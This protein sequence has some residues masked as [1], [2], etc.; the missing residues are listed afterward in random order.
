MSSRFDVLKCLSPSL[1]ESPVMFSAKPR[2]ETLSLKKVSQ[3]SP[4]RDAAESCVVEVNTSARQTLSQN[5]I[6]CLFAIPP[7]PFDLCPRS[8]LTGRIRGTS[9]DRPDDQS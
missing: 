3:S 9:E 8:M 5:K 4:K 1:T 2:N 6:R 7:P